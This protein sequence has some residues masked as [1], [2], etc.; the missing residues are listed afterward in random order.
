M[1]K[2]PGFVDFLRVDLLCALQYLGNQG[3][4]DIFPVY[5]LE[6]MNPNYLSMD[7]AWNWNIDS[8]RST[9]G[10]MWG[11]VSDVS[12]SSILNAL[13]RLSFLTSHL[14]CVCHCRS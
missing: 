5:S 4:L 11:T 1:P 6:V 13:A 8:S 10:I 12:C 2:G 3:A 14:L 7:G 9:E